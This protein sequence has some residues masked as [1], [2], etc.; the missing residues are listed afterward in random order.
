MEYDNELSSQCSIVWVLNQL[1]VKMVSLK[2]VNAVYMPLGSPS[3]SNLSQLASNPTEAYI[4]IRKRGWNPQPPFPK[5]VLEDAY[6]W[7]GGCYHLDVFKCEPVLL[8]VLNVHSEDAFSGGASWRENLKAMNKKRKAEVCLDVI[9]T[10]ELSKQ[11]YRIFLCQVP[12]KCSFLKPLFS[13][14]WM[15]ICMHGCFQKSFQWLKKYSIGFF[16]LIYSVRGVLPLNCTGKLAPLM[17]Q[18]S[19]L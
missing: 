2:I 8:C 13:V 11:T 4:W 17:Q 9:L 14:Y 15:C 6:S 3:W 12:S 10:L 19:L 18:S 5:L 1:S 16:F 7:G